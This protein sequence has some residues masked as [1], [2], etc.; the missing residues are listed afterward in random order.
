MNQNQQPRLFIDGP[1]P[2]KRHQENLRKSYRRRKGFAIMSGWMA[3]VMAQPPLC[4]FCGNMLVNDGQLNGHRAYC[5]DYGH[6]PSQGDQIGEHGR[7]FLAFNYFYPDTTPHAQNMFQRVIVRVHERDIYRWAARFNI[8]NRWNEALFTRFSRQNITTASQ[9][10]SV[11]NYRN[12]SRPEFNSRPPVTPVLQNTWIHDICTAVKEY[13][14][15][16]SDEL[17]V[18]DT[19]YGYSAATT[20]FQPRGFPMSRDASKSY[21]WTKTPAPTVAICDEHHYWRLLI[22]PFFWTEALRKFDREARKAEPI[23]I[24]FPAELQPAVDSMWADFNKH[25]H[26]LGPMFMLFPW[27]E[28]PSTTPSAAT[29]SLHRIYLHDFARPPCPEYAI[30]RSTITIKQRFWWCQ[31]ER[32][33]EGNCPNRLRWVLTLHPY[34]FDDIMV[35]ISHNLRISTTPLQFS[36]PPEVQNDVDKRAKAAQEIFNMDIQN[37]LMREFLRWVPWNFHELYSGTSQGVQAGS[38]GTGSGPSGGGSSRS[39]YTDSPGGE[40]DYGAQ[41]GPSSK[42]GRR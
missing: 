42:H 15:R 38:S 21:W 25:R 22:H 36:L 35:H 40:W 5:P 11:V 12:I 17:Q 8:A 1:G 26:G 37:E 4:L 13:S 16:H 18:S 32:F 6:F 30:G 10:T 24:P 9:S 41:A 31:W 33:E 28:Q 39:T 23:C 3:T 7:M 19:G 20:Y 29:P 2:D 27:L 14:L 34:Y